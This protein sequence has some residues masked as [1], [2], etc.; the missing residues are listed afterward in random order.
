MRPAAVCRLSDEP[1]AV[2]LRAQISEVGEGGELVSGAAAHTAAAAAHATAV[3]A[4]PAA[5]AAAAAAAAGAGG[6]WWLK[7][8]GD[9]WRWPQAAMTF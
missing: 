7:G 5:A 4:H 9:E 3:A 6:A 2:K 1:H 8:E